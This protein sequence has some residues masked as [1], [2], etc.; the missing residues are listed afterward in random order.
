MISVLK[1]NERFVFGSNLKGEHYGGAA[2][3]AY[4]EFDAE[5]GIG[6]GLTGDSYA[7]PTLDERMQRFEA[8]ELESIK[9]AFFRCCRAHPELIFLL[10]KVGCGIAGYPE[11]QM[12]Q[13]FSDTPE[14]VVKPK[15]W[16]DA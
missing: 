4:R 6:E 16:N 8:E 11:E 14:N 5:W 15:D 12:K 7:F 1:D 2:D 9:Q 3:Q 13:L 10:T